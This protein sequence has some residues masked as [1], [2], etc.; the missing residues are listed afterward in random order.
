MKDRETTQRGVPRSW[1]WRVR[2]VVLLTTPVLAGALGA[3]AVLLTDGFSNDLIAFAVFSIVPTVALAVVAP[4][5]VAGLRVRGRGAAPRS[6]LLI[7]A[8]AVVGVG[9][10]VPV[11]LVLGGMLAMFGVPYGAIWAIACGGALFIAARVCGLPPGL[12]GASSFDWSGLVVRAGVTVSGLLVL[13]Y[14]VMMLNVALY[15][16][17]PEIHL[18]PL[19]FTGPV[20]IIHGDST[21]APAEY[22]DGAR[23]YRI[24]DTGVLR[25]QFEANQG[26][27]KP[28]RLFYANPDGTR[29]RAVVDIDASADERLEM[30]DLGFTLHV[31]M[32]SALPT[33]PAYRAYTIGR[34]VE[35]RGLSNRGHRVVD[36]VI[37][38]MW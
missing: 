26:W 37:W 3:L 19:G 13:P 22:E 17:E 6:W 28:P 11:T 32:D 29:A 10:V 16:A 36:S 25:T 38:G 31:R 15:R 30:H 23:V 33:P 34:R 9:V 20:V 2:V 5:I 18:L 14:L 21:G 4:S 8:G 1:R 27:H 35:E 7:A 24:P 12:D